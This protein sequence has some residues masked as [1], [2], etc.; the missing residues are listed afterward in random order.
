MKQVYQ[1]TKFI[2][3]DF[4]LLFINVFKFCYVFTNDTEFSDGNNSKG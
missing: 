1:K 3:N 2:L 4:L